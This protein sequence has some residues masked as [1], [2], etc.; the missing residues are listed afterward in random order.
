MSELVEKLASEVYLAAGASAQRP[1]QPVDLATRILGSKGLAFVPRLASEGYF[2][3][4]VGRGLIVVRR[5]LTRRRLAHVIGHELGHWICQR[6]GVEDREDL[7]DAI[8]AAI[9]APRASFLARLRRIGPRMRE[10]AWAYQTTQ[11]LAALRYAEVTGTPLALVTPGL[12]RTRG[13]CD[14][15]PESDLR[16]LARSGG[17]GDLRA[18]RLRDDPRRVL[19][20]PMACEIA[21]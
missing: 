2:L 1:E 19:L 8:G 12:V 21:T 13:E 15:P 10:L 14:W 16:E 3:P 18:V 6:E 17:G 9:I 4:T 11:S 5:G 20:A 7:C